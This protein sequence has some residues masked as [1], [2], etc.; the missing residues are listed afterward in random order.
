MGFYTALRRG[1]DLVSAYV[2]IAAAQLADLITFGAVSAVAPISGETDVFV[3]M[4]YGIGGLAAVVIV[5][6]AQIGAFSACWGVLREGPVW[7][8][9]AALAG[10]V[11]AGLAGA[12]ANLATLTEVIR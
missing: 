6:A 10:I 12:A 1:P 7:A 2:A 11:G 3:R 5:K 8:R 9:T 4:A